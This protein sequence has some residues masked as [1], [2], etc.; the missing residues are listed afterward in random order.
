LNLLIDAALSV[1][2]LTTWVDKDQRPAVFCL[3]M[4]IEMKVQCIT[5]P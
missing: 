3:I 2:F 5:R 1:G 4:W